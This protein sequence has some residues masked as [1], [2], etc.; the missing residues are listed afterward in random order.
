MVHDLCPTEG[1]PICAGS[2]FHFDVSDEVADV[3]DGGQWMGEAQVRRVP[4][5]VTG[6]FRAYISDRSEWGYL[7]VALSPA[8]M[9]TGLHRHPRR[10]QQTSN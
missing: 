9:G 3:I 8:V 4:C 2:H 10:L 5:P 7:K 6:T 1:N